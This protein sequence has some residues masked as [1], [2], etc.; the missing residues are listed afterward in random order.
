MLGGVA[1]AIAQV[2]DSGLPK[3][4]GVPATA[5]W[6]LEARATEHRR[7]G[8]MFA[9]PWAE[10]WF[11]RL[12]PNA[13]L[14][15]LIDERV[16]LGVCMRAAYNDSSTLAHL[17]EH[18]GAVVVELACGF[19][20]RCL[21]LGRRDCRWFHLDLPYVMAWRRELGADD[22]RVSCIAKSILDLSWMDDVQ[23]SVGA[24]IEPRK[25]LLIMEG[26][27]MYLAKDE[28]A[29]LMATLRR[30]WP[31]ARVLCDCLTPLAG[32]MFNRRLAH[33]QVRFPWGFNDEH[34]TAEF[35]GIEVE[36]SWGP[37]PFFAR[38]GLG[39]LG[40]VL[41]ARDLIYVFSGRLRPIG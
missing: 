13:D 37:K 20:S 38:M 4:Q 35:L 10:A 14:T 19:S 33:M 32:N 23:A 1:V 41:F 26:I 3:L 31:G 7:R 21:R 5:Q 12:P 9:D 8:R 24:P 29:A 22:E 6:T 18:D 40:R 27:L 30:R 39:W 17:N 16:R 34:A 25:L 36:Q 28:V 15:S 11:Q 2:N